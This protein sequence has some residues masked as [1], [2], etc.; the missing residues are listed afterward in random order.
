M[1]KRMTCL[2]FAALFLIAAPL[3][4]QEEK[5]Q[6]SDKGT[7]EIQAVTTPASAGDA[8]EKT[9]EQKTDAQSGIPDEASLFGGE[10]VSDNKNVIKD[11][12]SSVIEKERV[13]FSGSLASRNSY[14]MTRDWMGGDNH[15]FKN[16]FSAWFDAN[17]NL[18]IR[19]YSGVKAYA[20]ASLEYY[21][22]E[23]TVI[24]ST[25]K[26]YQE[27]DV[28]YPLEEIFIDINARKHAY[29][30]IGKQ[31]LKWGVGYL[32]NPTDVINIERKNILDPYQ[33]REGVYGLKMTVPVGTRFNFY[34]FLNFNDAK[35]V[36]RIGVSGKAEVLIGNTEMALSA[37]W[38]RDSHPVIG[39]EITSRL[40]TID[41]HGEVSASP[42]TNGKVLDGMTV[43]ENPEGWT[44]MIC[45][46][47]GRGFDV[48]NVHDRIR[49]DFEF[50]YNHSG[51][52][53]K[54]FNNDVR[55]AYFI[56]SGC[57][58]PNYYGRFY[59]G[60]FMTVSQLGTSELSASVNWIFN[61]EDQSSVIMALL[62]WTPLY[63]LELSFG[64]N[65]F[66]GPDNAEYT[67]WNGALQT[68]I[69]VRVV[70]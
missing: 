40:F 70:F 11:T 69:N 62:T 27:N 6:G 55:M 28:E 66:P 7:Q 30:R 58:A 35:D 13:S 52:T 36:D 32:W 59:T 16:V 42:G 33:V 46:G 25:F 24:S 51:Y 68:Q 47:L 45:A 31:F 3:A 67:F 64:L 48:L 17:F 1:K 57:Y 50:F 20:S 26:T 23:T 44:T 61:I 43:K 41:L 37:S 9:D 60:L 65:G 22:T 63:N 2:V 56:Q 53:E 4:A 5:T 12:V 34:A 19:L 15:G 29:F 38:R 14:T 49:L 21:P 39:Y 18:D 54:I 8:A 10:T